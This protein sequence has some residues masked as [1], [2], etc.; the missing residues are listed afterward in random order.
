MHKHVPFESQLP[1]YI[2][3][4]PEI[5]NEPTVD[6]DQ[7]GI[8]DGLGNIVGELK[9][10]MPLFR[11]WQ[12]SRN[13]QSWSFIMLMKEPE[14]EH[15]FQAPLRDNVPTGYCGWIPSEAIGQ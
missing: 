14:G 15:L 4:S 11:L 10:G 1:T 13:G 3:T 5:R 12:E 8:P 2:R 9:P 6:Y 7:D